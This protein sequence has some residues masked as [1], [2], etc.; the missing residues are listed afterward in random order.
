LIKST[1]Y[2][3]KIKGHPK[4]EKL[5]NQLNVAEGLSF[6]LILK[7]ILSVILSVILLGYLITSALNNLFNGEVSDPQ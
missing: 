6:V 2:R 1:K 4:E 5:R 7:F 3:E